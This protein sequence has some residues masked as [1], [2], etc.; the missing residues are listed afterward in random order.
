MSQPSRAL[1][2][3]SG[4]ADNFHTEVIGKNKVNPSLREALVA[5]RANRCGV[6]A[7]S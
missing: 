5:A 2:T 4:K 6:K 1:F 3:L 7:P